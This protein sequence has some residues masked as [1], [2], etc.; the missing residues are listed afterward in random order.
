MR[1]SKETKAA[2]I[3]TLDLFCDRSYDKGSLASTTEVRTMVST[4]HG[5]GMVVDKLQIH[6]PSLLSH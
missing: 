2:T 5:S 6:N 3:G 1:R 4:E